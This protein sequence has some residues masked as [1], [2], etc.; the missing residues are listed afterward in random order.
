MRLCFPKFEQL[1]VYVTLSLYYHVYIK[2]YITLSG[3]P[4]NIRIV[5]T[6]VWVCI[7]SLWS[8][9]HPASWYYNMF[10]KESLMRSWKVKPKIVVATESAIGEAISTR[11][12]DKVEKQISKKSAQ[13]KKNI[14]KVILDI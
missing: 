7:G 8:A 5:H 11:T 14:F 13:I 6:V 9:L 10:V 2:C 1:M 4:N 12:L 3:A